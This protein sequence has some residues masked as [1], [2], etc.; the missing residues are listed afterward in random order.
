[1]SRGDAWRRGQQPQVGL[2]D[3][4]QQRSR[5]ALESHPHTPLC[6]EQQPRRAS[7]TSGS[8]LSPAASAAGSAGWMQS[9]A[10]TAPPS[11]A[12]PPGASASAPNDI[13]TKTNEHNSILMT[14]P[15]FSMKKAWNLLGMAESN[16]R[17]DSINCM[18]RHGA[19]LT[20]PARARLL[21]P[22][23]RRAMRMAQW[24]DC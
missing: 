20:Q 4:S 16:E 14:F 22:A 21:T 1:M 19:M 10:G 15:L 7:R 5:P 2:S 6:Q 17:Y 8:S 23:R 9:T 24:S 3:P 13:R 12:A 18:R 11:S